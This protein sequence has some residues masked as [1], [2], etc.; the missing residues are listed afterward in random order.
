MAYEIRYTRLANSTK[1]SDRYIT[2][3]VKNS[4]DPEKLKM[5][6]IFAL[7]EITNPWYPNSQIGQSIINVLTQEYYKQD[8]E[9]LLTNF[10]NALKK[11]NQNLARI[12][13]E[14]ESDW[15]G[16]INAILALVCDNEI[17][18]TRTGKAEA[19]LF[20]DN[21]VNKI[22]DGSV[23]ITENPLKTFFDIVSGE[24][25]KKDKILITSPAL[26]DY[27]SQ[28][29][30]QDVISNNSPYESMVTISQFLRQEKARHINSVLLEINSKSDSE[31]HVL[32][33]KDVVYLDQVSN[34]NLI[35]TSA[36][37][38]MSQVGPTAE[39][40]S[41]S[42]TDSYEKVKHF[43]IKEVNPRTKSAWEKTKKISS[44]GYT[45]LKTKTAPQVKS[46]I[47]PI[48]DKVKTNIKNYV[49]KPKI[50]EVPSNGILDENAEPYS[51]NYYESNKNKSKINMDK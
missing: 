46:M 21:K 8:N 50:E 3:Q 14:G 9:D 11:V 48:S 37:K 35:S 33:N 5:G 23:Q 32:D 18:L 2:V 6:T 47:Q 38:Y 1:I 43:F 19:F 49:F 31:N 4:T 7:I 15:I 29:E 22:T 44:D 12:T 28:K 36:K 26:L 40:F 42:V 34:I 16:N 51:V 17:H 41:K 39:N 27:L 10:E 30:I 24:I 45:H 25:N 20:R 13:Q